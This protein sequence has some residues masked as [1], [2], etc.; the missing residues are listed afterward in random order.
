MTRRETVDRLT[1]RLVPLYGE[2]EARA[3]A[4]NAVAELAGLPLSALLT[5]PRGRNSP[6]KGWRKRRHS[7]SPENPCNMSSDTPNSAATVSPCAKE[8]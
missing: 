4:R 3:I 1:A 6:Q 5:D 8:C 2:R 7:S